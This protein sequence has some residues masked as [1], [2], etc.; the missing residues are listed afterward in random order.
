[1]GI[2]QNDTQGTTQIRLSDLVDVDAV[3]TDL[4]ILNI[5]ETVDQVG[6][7]GLTGSGGTDKGNLLSRLRI[8]L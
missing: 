3:V 7:R 1:M 8:Q 4:T 5:I 6:D 2:L